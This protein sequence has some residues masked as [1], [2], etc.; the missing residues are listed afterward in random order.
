MSPMT[1]DPHRPAMDCAEILRSAE[2]LVD[3]E[4]EDRERAEALA[5]LAACA[6]CRATVG[7]LERTRAAL[8]E[9]L[10]AAL[11]PASAEGRAP[12]AL[13]ARISVAL[14]RERLPWWRRAL[15]P[16][17]VAA[18]AAC[19]A[20]ALF[21]LYTH[22]VDDP[23]ADE[24]VAGHA[25]DLPLDVTTASTGPDAL[26]RW[27]QGKVGF[28]TRPPELRQTGMRL[29]GARVSNIKD[30]PAAYVRYEPP[31][32]VAPGHGTLGLF[33]VEDREHRFG[34]AGREVQVGPSTVR[35]LTSRGYNVVVWRRDEIVYSLVS[36]LDGR[37]L[38]QV[39]QAAIAA[40]R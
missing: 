37:E 4:F 7:A 8:R 35:M 14:R 34:S 30:R 31:V 38:E 24:S 9:K 28:N 13:R 12:A 16:L 19:A 21:V 5:H 27:F 17:P 15:A 20:G 1:F 40:Q 22:G 33:I 25:R 23:L 18:A 36:D 32:P 39:V 26:A 3:G 10:R 11:G 6:G 2:A 29:V